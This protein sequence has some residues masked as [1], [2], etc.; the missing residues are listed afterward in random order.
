M[1]LDEIKLER[2]IKSSLPSYSGDGYGYG[3]GA[4]VTIGNAS[5]LFGEGAFAH[6]FA[7]EVARRWNAWNDAMTRGF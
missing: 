1:N 3:G 5:L 6:E 7:E 2:A 4:V